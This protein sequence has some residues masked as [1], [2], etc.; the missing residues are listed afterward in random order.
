MNYPAGGETP[1][2]GFEYEQ[3]SMEKLSDKVKALE[4]ARTT[5]NIAARYMFDKPTYAAKAEVDNVGIR[6]LGPAFKETLL[7]ITETSDVLE[8]EDQ[9]E[10]MAGVYLSEVQASDDLQH[11]LIPA[12]SPYW[13]Q[14]RS[15][16]I[17][18]Q[19]FIQDWAPLTHDALAAAS[20]QTEVEEVVSELAQQHLYTLSLDTKNLLAAARAKQ[21]GLGK[22]AD[23]VSEH[24]P[25]IAGLAAASAGLGWLTVRRLL[26]RR[27][28][29][30]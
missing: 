18:R 23:I 8:L 25:E 13:W 20:N 26:G 29:G 1:Q 11:R 17:D 9:S 19:Q 3:T 22:L 27:A 24:T 2:P 28:A 5:F 4:Y 16:A 30:N 14:S 7:A 6:V 10:M 15:R 12:N 21:H